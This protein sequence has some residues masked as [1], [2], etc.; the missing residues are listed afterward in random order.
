MTSKPARALIA[1]TTKDN[2]YQRAH[3]AS[4]EAVANHL[5]VGLEIIYAGND[6]VNQVQQILSAIQR[7]NHGFDVIIT[8]PVGTG[9]ASVAEAA[10]KMG[11]GWCVM[12]CEADYVSRLRA[13]Y[14]APV[15]EASVDQIEVG[16]IQAQQIAAVLPDGG[17]VLYI[18]GPV[19]GTAAARR[20]E[21]M[22][23]RKPANIHFKTLTGN[24]TEDGGHRVVASWLKLS[25]SQ[26]SPFVAV[27][28]QND[29]MAIGARRAFS[30]LGNSNERSNWL[31]MP[32]FGVDGLPDTGQQFVQRKQLAATV[33]MPAVAG[34]AL[35]VYMRSQ[36]E[37]KPLPE[38]HLVHPQSFPTVEQLR[39]EPKKL[40]A[41]A[42]PIPDRH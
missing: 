35:E 34:L 38:R 32:F 37:G 36:L 27:V 1:L 20:T 21:G 31:K 18:T 25:T 8:E 22:M 29:A 19:S 33:I 5:G 3:A 6:A 17:T 23:S 12:N 2:D 15:F 42:V 14:N 16:R 41:A 24:W 13:Q 9:M 11:L 4:A 40:M 39:P 30:E 28:S 26:S 10:A 7:P